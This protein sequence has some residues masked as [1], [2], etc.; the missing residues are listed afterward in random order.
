[1]RGILP[2][3]GRMTPNLAVDL[4]T[5]NAKIAKRGG[6]ELIVDVFDSPGG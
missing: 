3:G 1:M 4:T 2:K 6:Y 5:E